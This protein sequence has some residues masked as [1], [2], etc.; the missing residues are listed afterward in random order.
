MCGI[1][2]LQGA[3]SWASEKGDI[4]DRAPRSAGRRLRGRAVAWLMLA[5]LLA[6]AP[7]IAPFSQEAYG[8]AVTLKVESLALMKRATEPYADH[9]KDVEALRL[10][11]QRAYEYAKGRPKNTESTAQW[12]ILNNPQG[13][14]LGGFLERWREKSTLGGAFVSEVRAKVDSAF[15]RII[16]L[17]SGKLKAADVGR[18]P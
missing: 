18:G 7:T 5:G 10:K 14:L 6:C 3:P 17:E 11:L 2:T 13:N 12:E 16:G 8:I 15:D 1:Q 4:A 9:E